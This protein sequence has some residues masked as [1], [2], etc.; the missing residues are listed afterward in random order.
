[1]A[2]LTTPEFATQVSAVRV[3]LPM[4]DP[5]DAA[6]W[7][8]MCENLLIDAGVNQQ[9]TMFRKVLAKLPPPQFRLV[10]HLA[11]QRPLPNDCFDKLQA[12]LKEQLDPTPAERLLKMESLPHCVGDRKPSDLYLELQALY[13]NDMDHEIIQETFL[14]RMPSTLGLLCRGWLEELSLRDVSIRAD[15]Y[16][17]HQPDRS[18][19]A[20]TEPSSLE[21]SI[22]EE[23]GD[24]SS[25]VEAKCQSFPRTLQQGKHRPLQPRAANG[26]V[27]SFKFLVADVPMAILGADFLREQGLIPDLRAAC[28][29]DGRTFLSVHSSGPQRGTGAIVHVSVENRCPSNQADGTKFQ[30]IRVDHTI[31]TRGRPVYARS[32][33]LRPD[34]WPPQSES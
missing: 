34:K 2:G 16:R 12:C 10:K 29:R 21:P 8:L 26:R 13:P 19:A 1:M 11:L 27:Y 20:V 6:T 30:D 5:D 9:S 31:E 33:R 22:G 17:R 4:F 7:L 15:S 32:R 14:Q 18:A 25:T 3:E 23:G 28:L 24:T